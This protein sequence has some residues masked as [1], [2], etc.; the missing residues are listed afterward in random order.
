M[1]REAIIGIDLGGTKVVIGRVEQGR[2]VHHISTAVSGQGSEEQVIGEVI[3]AVEQVFDQ[4]V[5]GIGVGVPSV[6]DVE[7]G[8][9]YDVQNIP[10]WREVPL[11]KIL[12]KRFG[13]PVYVN[14]DANCFAVGEK[15]SG[16]GK[17]FRHLVGLIIGTGLGAGII[18]NNRLY[19]GPN[20]G[21]GEFGMIPYKDSILE[22]YCSGQYFTRECGVRGEEVHARAGRGDREGLEILG[23]FGAFL[24]DALMIIMLAVDPEAIIL[25][26]SVSRSFPFF[27]KPMRER[28][29]AFPYHK[30]LERIVIKPSRR[31]QV[32]ILGAAALYYDARMPS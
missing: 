25:G 19:S 4:D 28:M 9:V 6:V 5:A 32:A 10:S 15:Y 29:K 14:N 21:A 31:P 18:L 12:E 26:G 16:L 13:R 23:R 20:C 30:T 7:K 17:P 27:E 11:K 3:E 2:I 24:G 8:I 22:H 1:K